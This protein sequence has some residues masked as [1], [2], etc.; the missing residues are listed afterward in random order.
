MGLIRLKLQ[1]F[2]LTHHATDVTEH[3]EQMENQVVTLGGRMMS[4]RDMG[5]ASFCDLVDRTGR[6]QLYV[7]VDEV[8]IDEYARFRKLDIGDIIGAMGTVFKTHRGET[9]IHVTKITLLAKSLKPLPEKFHG[10]KDPDL[11][12]RQRY[13]DLIVNP[14]VRRTFEIR[15]AVIKNFRSFLDKLGFMEVETPVLNTIPGGANAKPF[16]THHNTLDIDM[17]LRI[18]TE[19]HLKRL[20]VGGLE[21]VYEIGR[22]FRN[23]GMSVKHNP[24]FTT[25]ELYQAFADYNDMMDITEGIITDTAQNVLGTTKITYQGE[26]IDLAPGWTRM[27]MTEAVKK[28]SG[29]DFDQIGTDGEAQKAVKATGVTF[30]G[31]PSRGDLLNLMFEQTVEEKLLQPTFIMDYPV[32]VSPLAKRKKDD[33]RL[34]ERFELFITR[35]E[36]ANAFSELNDPIDQKERFFRQAQLRASRR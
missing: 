4:K 14:E 36:I 26:E 7:K 30:A 17:Y 35:R 5:K 33:P 11:R 25:I 6:I 28:Y 2:P 1:K 22:I 8:G 31:N 9:S 20:I 23:E 12:Y 3:F 15:S 19:L 18:A 27:T 13:V 10:L 21:R 32:E 34:T 24:E 16:V 29:V